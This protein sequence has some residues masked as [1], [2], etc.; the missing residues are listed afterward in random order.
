ME[1]ERIAVIGAGITGLSIALALQMAGM[2][3]L[4]V[5]LED[6]RPPASWGNAGHIAIEQ[7]TP[8][9][10][11][12]ALASAPRRLTIAG[13]AFALPLNGLSASIPFG[14]RMM[15]ASRPS[16]F[17]AGKTWLKA[18]MADAMPAWRELVQ[19]IDR[20][21]LLIEG[22]HMIVWMEPEAARRGIAA[23]RAMDT[24]TARFRPA[25]PD[26]LVRIGSLVRR[27]PASGLV[28]ENTAQVL[29][30]GAVLAALALAFT[31]AGG[32][33]RTCA[34]DCLVLEG[35]KAR[36]ID[37]D[38]HQIEAARI[39][40]AA[41]VRSSDLLRP[42][43]LKVPII[44]ERGYHIQSTDHDWP[45][46]L[47]PLVFEERS[48]IVTRFSGGLRAASFVELTRHDAP[49]NEGHWRTLERHVGELGL[50][51]RGPF[52]HWHGSRPTLP[53]Y[54]PAI[55]KAPQADNLFYAFGHQHL[56][57]T[58]APITARHVAAMLRDGTP[59]PALEAFSL[60]RFH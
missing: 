46:D 20:P 49:P 1:L 21:D 53:D 50:P 52:T 38:G 18:L 39:V 34:I 47:P 45:N 54:L 42:L 40:V 12:A 15:A 30:P 29:D 16:V 11:L 7:V 13:G 31:A 43:G 35:G 25:K 26:E 60:R 8:L 48:T 59:P 2:P 14:F 4:L 17:E 58:L 51:M 56:G 5:S 27:A 33:R 28:F 6:E 19:T 44:A 41:G 57:L 23:W 55:G 36:A 32:T 3:T 10:S 24:G 37:A 22:G 9:A